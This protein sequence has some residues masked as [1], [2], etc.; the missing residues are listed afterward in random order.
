MPNRMDSREMIALRILDRSMMITNVAPAGQTFLKIAF[1]SPAFATAAPP[2]AHCADT[3]N[4]DRPM[5]VMTTPVTTGGKSLMMRAKN[6]AIR[7]PMAADAMT[8]PKTAWIP[9]SPLTIAVMV[10]TPANEVPWTKGN[11]EPK[12]LM[13]KD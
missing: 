3:G 2:M 8:A 6:G 1:S 10:A 9:P 13:P 7:K 11:W 5:V 4:R 12:N